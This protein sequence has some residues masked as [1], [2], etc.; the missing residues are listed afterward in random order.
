M[1]KYTIT[2]S[3]AKYH[4]YIN[5]ISSNAGHYLSRRPYVI[6]LIKEA[7]TN[8][9]LNGQRVIV[10]VDM[11]REIGNTDIVSTQD[12]DNIYYAKPIKNDTF[13]RFAKNKYPHP[14]RKLSIILIKDAE[15]QYE[16]VDTWIGPLKP[17]FPGDTNESSD[18]KQYWQEHALVHEAQMIQTK[19]ITKIC[20]Y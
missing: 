16:I 15:D 20:P 17:P 4:V 2:E 8:K 11:G 5:M 14:S 10:E 18:S 9:P 19:T 3:D 12:N 1:Y 7:L 13:Y 6:N